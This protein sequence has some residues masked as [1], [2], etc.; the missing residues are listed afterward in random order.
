LLLFRCV[1]ELG[2]NVIKH[3][4]AGELKV[5]FKS[6]DKVLEIS[7]EDDGIG[8]E[9]TPEKHSS[10]RQS[11]GLFSIQERMSNMGGV[12]KIDSALNKGT[13]VKLTLP[14]K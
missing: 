13:V 4:R 1:K 6:K 12:M 11:F 9:Y 5:N 14:L 10:N 3:S 8:F 7:V 2:N